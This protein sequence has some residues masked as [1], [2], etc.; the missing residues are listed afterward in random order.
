MTGVGADSDDL[1]I[2]ALLFGQAISAST[3][4]VRLFTGGNNYE[5]TAAFPVV[6]PDKPWSVYV[7]DRQ[8]FRTIGVDFDACKGDADGDA[9]DMMATITR[10]ALRAVLVE[11]G[12]TG[13][14]HV[15]V[16]FRERVKP[17]AVALLHDQLTSRYESFDPSCMTPASTIRPPYAP[18]R[19]GGTSTVLDQEPEAA[20]AALREGNRPRLLADVL[21]AYG[22]PAWLAE[23]AVADTDIK[24][25]VNRLTPNVRELLTTGKKRHGDQSRSGV[26]WSILLGAINA[27]L[28]FGTTVALLREPKHRAGE[29]HRDKITRHGDERALKLLWTEW[30]RATAYAAQHPIIA[31]PTDV[32]ILLAE[33][34]DLRCNSTGKEPPGAPTAPSTSPP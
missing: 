22:V 29:R 24:S 18:H 9:R 32:R 17:A 16:S 27:G 1:S 26:I 4:S 33:Q 5:E 10:S 13:G 25:A 15:F 20:L 19:F 12:P 6:P 11:S 28:D 31:S 14:R 21:T 30:E 7:A 8:G 3:N 2:S 23:H 34:L